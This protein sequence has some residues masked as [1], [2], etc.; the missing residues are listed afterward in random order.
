MSSVLERALAAGS[1]L[2]LN[3]RAEEKGLTTPYPAPWIVQL[4]QEI[5]VPFCFG[6]DSHSVDA[7]GVGLEEGRAYLLDLGVETITKLTR[8]GGGVV[9]EIVPL[10]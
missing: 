10:R 1:I 2:D 7:V 6:D 5:G 4:A 9:K 8:S 3:V